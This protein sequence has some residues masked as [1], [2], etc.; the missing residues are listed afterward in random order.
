MIKRMNQKS[1]S[2]VEKT[3]TSMTVLIS[4]AQSSLGRALKDLID[5]N[6]LQY[7]IDAIVIDHDIEDEQ[8]EESGLLQLLAKKQHAAG[9]N[10]SVILAHLYWRSSADWMEVNRSRPLVESPNIKVLGNAI[11]IAEKLEVDAIIFPSEQAC[12]FD[13]KNPYCKEKYIAESF[14]INSRIP[15]KFILKS[16]I[17][18]DVANQQ[19][20]LLKNIERLLHQPLFIPAWGKKQIDYVAASEMAET[21]L[22]ACIGKTNSA[23]CNFIEVKAN[24]RLKINQMLTNKYQLSFSQKFKVV[25]GRIFSPI[26]AKIIFKSG[27]FTSYRALLNVLKVQEQRHKKLT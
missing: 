4:G 1:V 25:V 11:K 3:Q 21:I 19:D 23:A 10:H 12:Q 9:Q 22:D 8:N 13:T 15:Q 5:K 27:K 24:H 18:A 26:F 17:V 16:A 2:P 7:G 6:A 14:I 20:E